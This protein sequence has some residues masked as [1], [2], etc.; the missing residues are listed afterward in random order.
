MSGFFTPF[1][2]APSVA[3][4]RATADMS[5]SDTALI[6]HMRQGIEIITDSQRYAGTLPRLDTGED[7]HSIDITVYG[8]SSEFVVDAKFEELVK[9]DPVAIIYNTSS[10]IYPVVLDNASF[11]DVE[12]IGGFIEPLTIDA[13]SFLV[14]T[15]EFE[16]HTVRGT[17]SNGNEDAFRRTDVI[18]DVI[19][20]REVVQVLNLYVDASDSMGVASGAINLGGLFPEGEKTISPFNESAYLN[21]TF[22]SGTLSGSNS[23]GIVVAMVSMSSDSD[24]LFLVGQKSPSTGF[25]YDNAP[26]GIDSIAF[27]GLRRS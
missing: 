1:V 23:Y 2:E 18:S 9:F 13:R 19:D 15:T 25:T 14:S 11:Q 6:D 3:G 12:T 8:Q 16:P 21:R 26:Y 24:I 20:S 7:D 17:I 10:M 5:G 27:G 22:I 4:V